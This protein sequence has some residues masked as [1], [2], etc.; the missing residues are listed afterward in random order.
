MAKQDVHPLTHVYSEIYK[1][2][3][4]FYSDDNGNEISNNINQ[5]VVN[6]GGKTCNIELNNGDVVARNLDDAWT[7]DINPLYN[8]QKTNKPKKKP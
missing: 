7:L 8:R 6:P 2:E 4:F 1:N 3:T 5:I